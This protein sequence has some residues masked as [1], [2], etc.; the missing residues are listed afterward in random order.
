MCNKTLSSARA[1]YTMLHFL[2]Q[3]F[4]T[5]LQHRLQVARSEGAYAK[6]RAEEATASNE[7][8]KAEYSRAQSEAKQAA[9][10]AAAETSSL[11]VSNQCMVFHLVALESNLLLLLL[12]KLQVAE[13]CIVKTPL[14]INL[15]Q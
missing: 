10:A 6:R 2:V 1:A 7:S 8:I 3:Y 5:E 11:Q 12:L 13:A 14:L 9:E 15:S 4:P